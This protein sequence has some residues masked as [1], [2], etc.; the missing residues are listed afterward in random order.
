VNQWSK[1]GQEWSL[2]PWQRFEPPFWIPTAK[3]ENTFF[4]LPPQWGQFF[5]TVFAEL[6][7]NSVIFPQL[8]HLYSKTG[9]TVNPNTPYGF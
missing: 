7:K 8:L 4:S 2:Q 1:C 6:C 3:V 9:I 5:S